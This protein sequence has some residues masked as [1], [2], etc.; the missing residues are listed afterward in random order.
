MPD[1][2]YLRHTASNAKNE[3]KMLVTHSDTEIVLLVNICAPSCVFLCL[4][5]T[6]ASVYQYQIKILWGNQVFDFTFSVSQGLISETQ[7]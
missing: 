3:M 4:A 1:E 2:L 6:H 7:S 5:Y